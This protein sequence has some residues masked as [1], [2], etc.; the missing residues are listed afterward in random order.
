[1]AFDYAS[2]L[3]DDDRVD[4]RRAGEIIFEIGQPGSAMYV[5]KS[6]IAEIRVGD[7]VFET[8]ERGATI[9]EMAILD[10]TVRSATA[11]AVTD[12]EIVAIDKARLL[13]QLEE[14]RRWHAVT[15]N[16]EGRVLQLKREVNALLAEAGRRPRYGAVKRDPA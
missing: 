10:D 15:R 7:R 12:C 8:V 1:M 5:I 4:L 14:L 16:R 9:G 11:V 2:L 13:A 3:A 6:G